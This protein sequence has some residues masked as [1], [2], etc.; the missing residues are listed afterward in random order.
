MC[1]LIV[2]CTA[3]LLASCAEHN[4]AVAPPRSIGIVPAPSNVQLRAGT[5][6]LAADATMAVPDLAGI[7]E[8]AEWVASLINAESGLSLRVSGPSQA[9]I[10][11]ELISAEALRNEFALRGVGTANESYVL[12]IDNQGIRIR[13]CDA[14]GLYYGL[15]S[16]W[17]LIAGAPDDQPVALP[18]LTISDTPAFAWRGLMLDSA[19]HFQS[20]E[21][22]KRYIDWMSLYKLNVFHWH[23]TDDQA[24]RLEIRSHPKLTG[25]GAWRVPAGAAPAADIDPVTERPRQYGGYYSQ[26]TVREIVLH[27]A[28][29]YV[30]I[31]PEVGVPGHASAAIAAY[32]DL[33]VDGHEVASVP[34][35][36][37]VF[38]NVLNVDE[39]TFQVLEDVYREVVEMFPG[40]YI[41]V[42]GDEVVTRQWEQSPAVAKR[43]QQLGIAD[44]QALQNYFVERLQNFLAGFD[45]KVIGWDEILESDLPADAAVMSWRGIDGAIDAAAAGHKTVLSPAPILYLDHLQTAAVDAPPGRGGIV[46]TRDIYEFD[47]LPDSLKANRQFLLGVQGNLWTEHVRTEDRV[48]YMTYPRAL[49]VAELGWSSGDYKSWDEFA[50]RLDAQMQHLHSLGIPAASF[51]DGPALER[52]DGR[53][54]DRELELCSNA[55]VLAIEDDAPLTGERESFLV[56]IMNPCWILRDADLGDART[57]RAAVG[58]VPFNFEIGDMINDVVVEAPDTTEGELRVRLDDCSGTVIASL[59]LAPATGRHA[60][61]ELPA[62][63]IAIDDDMKRT[64]DLCFSFTRRGIDP[65]WAIDWVQLVGAPAGNAK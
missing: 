13:A 61:T 10:R 41:H 56:D 16:L 2:T 53:I 15:T 60:V 43:M 64:A 26:Q 14:A 40:E 31:V 51:R 11:L 57:I 23:L 48:A 55:I 37:G 35:R 49:A 20:P 12:T 36:W 47:V 63:A 39:S 62:A 46:T 28:S 17:Q 30:T 27:A 8:S 38:D 45:R 4:E 1:R 5:F 9:E 29:R 58:Q 59:P 33:G 34:A 44:V 6:T 19:R 50:E 25:V 22:I 42:G 21:F 18:M 3:L 54:D 52:N 32:P 65:I 7:R 24:W